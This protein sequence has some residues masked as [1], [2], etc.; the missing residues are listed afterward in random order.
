MIT[1][2]FHEG[3]RL[4]IKNFY[5]EFAVV[6]IVLL[7]LSSAVCV[8]DTRIVYPSNSYDLLYRADINNNAFATVQGHT[9]HHSGLPKIDEILFKAYPG[10]LP[11]TI[12]N[13]FLAGMTD[14]IGG[15]SRKDLY[16]DVVAAGH[17]ISP[18]DPTAWFDFITINCRDYKERSGETNLPLNDSNFRLALSYIYGVDRKQA[19]IY[20]YY[21]IDW[22]YAIDNPVPPAQEPWYNE[23]IQM[24]NTNWTKAWSILEAAGYYVN[25]TENWLYYNG[26]KI[27]NMT[28]VG[29]KHP[30]EH[31]LR[32]ALVEAFNEFILTYLGANGPIMKNTLVDFKT[33]IYEVLQYHDFDFAC[34]GLAGLGRYVDWLYDL[35]HSEN[36]GWWGWN[37]GGISDPDIDKWTEI[38]LTSLD[39]DEIIDA[40]SKV[41]EKFVYELMPWIP[42]SS[43]LEFC[44]TA[45]DD[46]GELMNLVSMPYFGPR[47]DWSWMCLHWKGEPDEAWPGGT[48][49]T[50]LGDEPHSLNPY[51]EDTTYGWQMLDRA[52][53]GLTMAEPEN[54]MEMPFIATDCEISYWTSIPELGIV[55]G[56]KSTFWLRQDVT[57][58][59]GKPVTAYD[60]VANMRIMREYRPGRYSSTW[61]NMV[62]EEANG[63]YKFNIYF[64]QPSLYYTSYVAENALLV[65]KHIIELVEQQVENHILDNFFDWD[66]AFNTYEDLM[67][68]PPPTEYPF[69]KQ[70]VGCG[71]FVYDY[72]TRNLATGRVVRYQDFFVNAPVIGGVQGE[73]RI[74]PDTAF[75]YQPVV[76]NLGAKTNTAEGE[77]TN[78]TVDVK[79]YVDDILNY[80]VTDINLDPWEWTYLGPYT[81]VPMPIGLHTVKIEVCDAEDDS[82]IHTY[83][84][85]YVATIREDVNT[86][87]GELL[88]FTVDMRDVGRAARAFGSYPGHLRWDP[89][90]DV[91]DDYEVDMRDIGSIAR[92]F[93]WPA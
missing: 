70:I 90:C 87:T 18:M 44:T 9:V 59:D 80:T 35:L 91:N 60:C 4:N 88:D 39:V 69:M 55:N 14:W 22:H 37:Y 83:T 47:N 77:C 36:T 15:P 61:R 63:L 28:T 56:C 67:D 66:P 23:S 92:K 38:I 49:K 42:V 89:A 54:L 10:A 21:G 81:T 58:H 78:M 53:I 51:T 1:Q 11:E 40:A 2:V 85:A 62:Y 52:I 41:Q 57:W 31:Y 29:S 64:N 68:E 25:L 86:Y 73:W 74:D 84:H 6:T 34:F 46:R 79:V 45:R 24:P 33:F 71:P 8:S 5:I 48:V 43:G 30:P 76:Q 20:N 72:Y 26:A 12:V 16:D 17:K 32:K 7:M 19:D 27:R 50:G 13:D 75:T 82:L 3:I 65:P 93:G